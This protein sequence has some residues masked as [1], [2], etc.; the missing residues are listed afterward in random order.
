VTLSVDEK[1]VAVLF[2]KPVPA[3]AVK[4]LP[5]PQVEVTLELL[6]TKEQ[7]L[8]PPTF[9]VVNILKSPATVQL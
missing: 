8:L 1:E 6:C 5:G 3:V 4:A 7:S 2:P 9:Q